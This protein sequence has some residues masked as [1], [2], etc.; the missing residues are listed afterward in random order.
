MKQPNWTRILTILLVILAS[1]AVLYIAGSIL[2]RFKQAFFLFVLG[3]ITAYILTPLV[4]RLEAAFRLRWLAILLSY[5]LIAVGLFALGV[6][7]FTPFLQQ[8]QSLV[9]NLH[10]PSSGSLRTIV[11]VEKDTSQVHRNIKAERQ[12]VTV[13]GGLPQAR[14]T[15]TRAAIQKVQRDISDLKNGTVSGLSHTVSVPSQQTPGKV[16]PNPQP[17]T[18]VPPGYVAEITGSVNALASAY[19]TATQDPSNVDATLLARAGSDASKANTAAK[20][21]YHIM[22]TTPILLIRSQTWLDQHNIR[23]DLHSKFGD[24]ASQIS[25]QGSLLLNNAITILSETANT[26]LNITLI[27]IIS[28]YLLSD[29]GRI[30]HQGVALVPSKYREQVWFFMTSLDKVLGGYIRGQLFLSVLA[31]IL[32]GGGAAVLG[33]PY[34]L[35]IGIMT[36]LLETIPVIGPMVAVVPA[37]AISLFFNSIITT[38]LLTIWFLVFQQVVTNVIGPRIMGAAVGIHP[39]EALL[40][41]LVGY[42]L[43]GFLGAFLAVPVA[44]IVHILVRELYAYFVLGRDLPVAAVPVEAVAEEEYDGPTAQAATGR[45]TDPAA[46]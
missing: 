27:L 8:A 13:V 7:L 41:V 25:N 40:A 20:N 38:V 14:I 45:S 2:L 35:L 46:G 34:P 21:L 29:G 19:T 11:Q 43:G 37:V 4:N 3:A 33:V 10:N 44:G 9:D 28:F 15:L 32:G 26:L 30:L 5:A 1:W 39:L 18:Q 17:Q 31:G 16:P 24:A 42:P 22:S 6:L 23:V 36:F 12:V